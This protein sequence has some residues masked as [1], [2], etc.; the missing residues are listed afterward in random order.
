MMFFFKQKTAYEIMPSLVGSE[1]CIRDSGTA[2]RDLR[3]A[4]GQLRE[5]PR[6]GEEGVVNRTAAWILACCLALH[7]IAPARA[8]SQEPTRSPHGDLAEPCA[9]CHGP[10]GWT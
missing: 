4:L 3:A 1:M 10:S 8:W 5:L 6:R 7:A 9:T 2:N